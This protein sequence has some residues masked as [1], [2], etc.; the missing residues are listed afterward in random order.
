[1]FLTDNDLLTVRGRYPRTVDAFLRLPDGRAALAHVI[2]L[3]RRWEDL[4]RGQAPA[5]DIRWGDLPATDQDYDV[6]VAGGSLGLLTA[7]A[8]ARQGWRVMV[9]D[10]RV[11]GRAHR[12]WNISQEELQTV[13]DNGLFTWDELQSV[14]MRHYRTGLVHFHAG[15]TPT[16]EVWLTD[17][18]DVAVDAGA[19][20]QLARRKLETLGAPVLDGREFRRAWLASDGVARSV[21]EV[22]TADGHSERYGA[23]LLVNAMGAASPLSLALTPT[24]FSG[25]CPTVGTVA[26]GFARHGARGVDLNLGEILMTIDNA[27][28]G[29]RRQLMWEGFPGRHDELTVYLFYYDVVAADRLQSLLELFEVYFERLP[30]YK[31]PGPDFEHLRP[32]YGFIPS[33]HGVSSSPLARGVLAIGDASAH[34]SPLTFCGFGSH[35]RNLARVAGLTDYALRHALLDA[36]DLAHVSARQSN[37]AMMWVFARFMQPWR[38]GSEVNDLMNRF[39]GILVGLGPAGARR[40]FQDRTTWSDYTRVLL[41]FALRC[42]AVLYWAAEVIGPR[43]YLAWL[44]DYATFTRAALAMKAF[45]LLGEPLRSMA[46]AVADVRPAWGLR[47]RAFAGEWRASRPLPPDARAT[48]YPPAAPHRQRH[49]AGSSAPSRR[50]ARWGEPAPRRHPHDG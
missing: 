38:G 22:S 26:R 44:R 27:D 15:T 10:Q 9:F 24:P 39:L 45:D 36:A 7:L 47:L 13:V 14:V 42:P 31:A 25:V 19:L 21:V 20:L 29:G 17:V 6:V 12:E 34:Q 40:F 1:M 30:E 46:L 28:D 4:I 8:L 2:H 23:R 49:V 33:R 5:A 35:V 32:V 50:Q 43:G 16:Q 41:T 48:L 18:L 11:A 37:V 3:D